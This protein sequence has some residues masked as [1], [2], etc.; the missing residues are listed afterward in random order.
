MVFQL[1]SAIRFLTLV[2]SPTGDAAAAAAA[3]VDDDADAVGFSRRG[4]EPSAAG[5]N[6]MRGAT[7]SSPSLNAV[8]ASFAS[9]FDR[10]STIDGGFG[11]SSDIARQTHAGECG[12]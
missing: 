8:V 5:V 9:S 12:H 7:K 1:T 6:F 11:A 10:H 2:V 3:V 4:S